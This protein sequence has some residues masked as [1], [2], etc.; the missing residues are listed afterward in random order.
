[1]LAAVTLGGP[2]WPTRT[3]VAAVLWVLF[4]LYLFVS[5]DPEAWPLGPRRFAEIFEDARVVR[6]KLLE[7]IPMALGLADLA[8]RANA[9]SA[10]TTAVGMA[11][12][13]AVGDSALFYHDHEGGVHLDRVFLQ[14]AAIGFAGILRAGVLVVVGWRPASARLARWRGRRRWPRWVPCGCSTSSEVTG[15]ALSRDDIPAMLCYR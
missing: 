13:S 2:L 6:H 14:H 9:V 11:L 3:P 5:S 15:R 4:G 8:R 1:M 10:R 12:L 7:L